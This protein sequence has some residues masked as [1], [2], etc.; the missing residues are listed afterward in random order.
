MEIRKTD[1]GD[2]MSLFSFSE[3]PPPEFSVVRANGI[4][5]VPSVRSLEEFYHTIVT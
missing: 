4:F 2:P 3:S 1:L 5:A